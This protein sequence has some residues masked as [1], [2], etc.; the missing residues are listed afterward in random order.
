EVLLS[1][2]Q[3]WDWLGDPRNRVQTLM[4]LFVLSLGG[5]IFW[6]THH[7]SP[8]VSF[9]PLRER[10]FLMACIIVFCAFGVLYGASTSLPAMLQSLF[11]YDALQSGLVMSPSGF[12]SVIMMVVVGALLGVG[13][14]A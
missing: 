4:I 7:A 6:E 2:G 5:L 9:R 13:T 1:K 10:N 11:G 8:V 3:E 14:D 12:F